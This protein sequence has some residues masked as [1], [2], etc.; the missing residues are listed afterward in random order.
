[1]LSVHVHLQPLDVIPDVGCH[2][3]M[4][5][6]VTVQPLY[7]L[8]STVTTRPHRLHQPLVLVCNQVELWR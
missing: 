3:V 6:T 5:V 2:I 1:M 8:F 4:P 7:P